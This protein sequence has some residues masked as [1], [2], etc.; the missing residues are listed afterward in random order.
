MP[1]PSPGPGQ[2]RELSESSH[3]PLYALRQLRQGLER[4][5]LQGLGRPALEASLLAKIDTMLAALAGCEK[6]L[7][8]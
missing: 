2:V 5:V 6:I 8:T 1:S 7:R 4:G 3:P